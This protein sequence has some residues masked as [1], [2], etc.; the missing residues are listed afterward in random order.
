MLLR[1]SLEARLAWALTEDVNA[2]GVEDRVKGFNMENVLDAGLVEPE[3]PS[4]VEFKLSRTLYC[5]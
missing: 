3:D 1:L 4:I 5:Q 2:G